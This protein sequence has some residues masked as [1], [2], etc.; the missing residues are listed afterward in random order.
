MKKKTIKI[1]SL[2]L[3][4]VCVTSGVEAQN[5][6]FGKW[7]T[8]G[9]LRMDYVRE[10][11][12]SHDTVFLNRWVDRMSEWHGSRKSLLDPFNNGDYRVEMRD[13][14]SGDVI[15]SRCFSSLFREYRDT[16]AGAREVKRFEETLLL[17][18]PKKKVK[19]ALQRREAPSGPSLE[20]RNASE[21]PRFKDQMVVLFDPDKDSL[22]VNYRIGEL[23]DLE[24]HG[25]PEEKIDLVI[26]AQGYEEKSPQLMVDYYRIREALF[27]VEPFASH[28]GD[29]NVYGVFAD[30]DASFGT[31]GI[32]RYV[33]TESLWK[34][35]DRI[36][37]TPC[38]YII[39]MVNDNR[40][41]G[42]ALYN[43][44]AVSTM[45]EMVGLVLPHEMGHCLGGLADEYVD[46]N[47]SYNTLHM[48]D[49]EPLEPNITNLVDFGSKWRSMLPKGTPVPTPDVEVPRSEC[50]PLGV[51]EGAGYAPKGVY[52]PAMHCMMRDYAPFCPVCRQRLEEV[53][54]LYIR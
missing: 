24:V 11:D 43:T 32:D 41:G 46:E 31:F 52:R 25:S 19:V 5:V 30:V 29:F 1:L 48:K 10:G 54:G 2:A 7:F 6:K 17:P 53:F 15:Y 3:L 44:Y 23:S 36:G 47:L 45:H 18:M 38:D 8:G 39:I 28:R 40:Y 14:K 37:T 34:L 4:L 42:G 9:T 16:P 50:G 26:V 22:A 51:Y 27:G 33:M 35:H 21:Q 49:Y 13:A 20:R 12:A